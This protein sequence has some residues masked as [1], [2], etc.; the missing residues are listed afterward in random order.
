MKIPV[1]ENLWSA[2]MFP[3]GILEQWLVADGADVEDGQE[4]A[5]V[6]IEDAVHRM[7]APGRGRLRQSVMRNAVIEPGSII[8]DIVC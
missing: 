3:E 2:L 8:G 1:T 4:I 7:M 6:R 5:Q